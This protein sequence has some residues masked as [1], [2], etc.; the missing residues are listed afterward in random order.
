MD[1]VVVHVDCGEI[2]IPNA[3]APNGSDNSTNRF[4]ILNRDIIKLNYF[5]IYNR[6]GALVYESTDISKGWDGTY[7]GKIAPV[8]VY[9]WEADAFC[10]SGKEIKKHGNVTLLR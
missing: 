6:W 4:A 1:T 3:F 5:R 9:V 2:A 7:N 10:I 8:G